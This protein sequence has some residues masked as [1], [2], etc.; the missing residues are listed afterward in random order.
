MVP[1]F[2]NAE[3]HE[4]YKPKG[5]ID[6]QVYN[7]AAGEGQIR[8]DELVEVHRKYAVNPIVNRDESNKVKYVIR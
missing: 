5:L 2:K 6:G 1:Y 8:A 7:I 4:E 3:H